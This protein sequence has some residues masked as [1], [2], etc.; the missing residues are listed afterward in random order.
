MRF[1]VGSHMSRV[2]VGLVAGVLCA[3]LAM[4]APAPLQAQGTPVDCGDDGC[5]E[6]GECVPFFSRSCNTVCQRIWVWD[7]FPCCGHYDV[8]YEGSYYQRT[9]PDGKN[10]LPADATGGYACGQC[11]P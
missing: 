3:T 4:V 10:G 1:S 2:F 7:S 8:Y 9:C 11:T 6:S 5:P